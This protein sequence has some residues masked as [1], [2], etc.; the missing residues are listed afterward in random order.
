MGAAGSAFAIVFGIIWTA[1]AF[2]MTRNSPFGGGMLLFPLFGVA[3]VLFGIA[4]L[5]YNLKN[6]VS[7]DRFS[8]LDIIEPHEESDPLERRFG[9][10]GARGAD[11][12]RPIKARL[13]TLDELKAQGLASTE[14]YQTR[15]AAILR[16]I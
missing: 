2:S 8:V 4:Q 3:F 10:A 16:E 11:G 12:T 9:D 6:T 1:T 7:K 13:R 15:R 5:V 14:E